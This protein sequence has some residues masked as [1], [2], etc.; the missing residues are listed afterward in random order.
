ML[1]ATIQPPDEILRRA[2]APLCEAVSSAPGRLYP[3]IYVGPLAEPDVLAA[4]M[5][6]A[7][8]GKDATVVEWPEH[9]AGAVVLC[10]ADELEDARRCL[11]EIA[12]A[13]LLAW[14]GAA[15]DRLP[16][17]LL[18]PSDLG[19]DVREAI[20]APG[21]AGWLMTAVDRMVGERP[22]PCGPLAV[23]A[24]AEDL[25]LVADE[26]GLYLL[27]TGWPAAELDLG[28]R[29]SLDPGRAAI[30]LV[31]SPAQVSA[32]A[33]LADASRRGGAPLVLVVEDHAWESVA[34]HPDWA[35]A[36]R[37]SGVLAAAGAAPGA[38]G[39]LRWP[40]ATA[41]WASSTDPAPI[42]SAEAFLLPAGTSLIEALCHVEIRAR[43]ARLVAWTDGRFAVLEV[44]AG[45]TGAAVLG[46]RPWGSAPLVGSEDLLAELDG[47]RRSP[48]LLLAI[49]AEPPVP[50]DGVRES[51]QR[52][53][54]HFARLDDER[55]SA[56]PARERELAPWEVASA[57]VSFGLP[58]S[59]QALLSRLEREGRAGAEE[60]M[61]LA[62]L[63]ADERPSDAAALLRSAG[64]R[65]AGTARLDARVLQADAAALGLLLMVRERMVAPAEAWASV[66]AWLP[67]AGTEW[68]ED[69]RRA[70]LLFELAARAGQTE[71]TRRFA[72]T[73][74]RAAD[75]GDPL[76][77]VLEPIFSAIGGV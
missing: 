27:T 31:R 59:A 42:R 70:A 26:V 47:I 41:L 48:A 74:R 71:A 77:G 36:V 13:Q 10:R 66:E 45:G 73:F 22:G 12:D 46:V 2:L 38:L 52:I 44:E 3:V 62:Y 16:R 34:V 25:R 20:R 60:E 72:W 67:R 11:R 24:R 7:I 75:P 19:V 8:R 50:V 21:G 61:L 49:V 54:F 18:S 32:A 29:A 69:A 1:A 9:A 35:A 15:P 30:A 43:S 6:E 56:D 14:G 63:L 28:G 37:P 55:R 5:R 64:V 33:G 23:L 39:R 4:A 68:L 58:A 51:V 17:G 57:L 76:R 40:S 53:G 65:L